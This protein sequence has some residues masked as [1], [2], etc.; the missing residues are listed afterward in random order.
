VTQPQDIIGAEALAKLE[1]AGFSIM[2]STAV[3]TWVAEAEES[4]DRI[5]KVAKAAIR[6]A[7]TR[8]LLVEVFRSNGK[9]QVLVCDPDGNEKQTIRRIVEAIGATEIEDELREVPGPAP[10]A[11]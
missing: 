5:K 1:A 4:R 9:I 3:R 11:K 8:A 10:E 2:S 7:D 6:A